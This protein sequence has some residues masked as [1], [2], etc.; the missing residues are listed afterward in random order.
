[1]GIKV[2]WTT[3]IYPGTN[4]GCLFPRDDDDDQAAE[5]HIRSPCDISR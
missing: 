1:M 2:P 3:R 4:K 5:T